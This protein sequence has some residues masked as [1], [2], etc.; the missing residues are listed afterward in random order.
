MKKFKNKAFFCMEIHNFA[1]KTHYHN[2]KYICNGHMR[3]FS[4]VGL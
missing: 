1:S 3:R 4:H 2:E